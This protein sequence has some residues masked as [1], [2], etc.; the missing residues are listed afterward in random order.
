MGNRAQ[1]L[2]EWF[3]TR[4]G[5]RLLEAEAALVAKILP[6][7]FGF[8]LVQIG[9]MG[10]GRL[11]ES[12]RIH[13][14]CLLS[15]YPHLLTETTDYSCIHATAEQLPFAAD[16]IDVAILPH[17]LEFEDDPHQVLREVQRVLIPEGH[18]LIIGFNPMSL[19]GVWQWCCRRQSATAP[20]CGKFLSVMRTR[21]WL[22]LLGFEIRET[23][24]FY[25]TPPV[26]HDKILDNTLFLDKLGARYAKT[27]GAVYLIV[28]K[29]RVVSLTSIKLKWQTP[30]TLLSPQQL[31]NLNRDS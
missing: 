28:A 10:H 5:Q 4:L 1:Q 24:S 22:E 6:Q 13:H 14:R 8:H 25:Y 11:L 15:R 21:D 27:W 30:K 20:W 18:L 2:N 9:G 17:I 26:N 3:D 31:I 19:W 12:S 29:K 23:Y 7:L 16:S